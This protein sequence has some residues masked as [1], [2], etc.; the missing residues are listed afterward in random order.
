MTQQSNHRDEL[1]TI[2]GLLAHRAATLR[3]LPFI[4][5]GDVQWSYAQT[6]ANAETT[7]RS[8]MELGCER[9][10]RVAMMVENRPEFISAWFGTALAGGVHV[11]INLEYRGDILRHVLSDITA[12]ILICEDYLLSNV[13]AVMKE[14]QHGMRTIVVLGTA[15][16]AIAYTDVRIIA[17]SEFVEAGTAATP[18]EFRK[19]LPGDLGAILLTSGTTGVSKGVMV[20]DKHCIYHGREAAQAY[21]MTSAD[22]MYTC[23]PLFHGNAEW[24]TVLCALS[25][26]ASVA[27]SKRFSAS[28]FWE[29]VRKAGA[30]QIAFLGTM[31]HIL[32]GQPE[33]EADRSHRVRIGTSV[34]CPPDVMVAFERRFGFPLLETFGT[35]ETKRILSNLHYRRRIGSAGLPTP[36][37]TVEIHDAQ[38]WP[39]PI[40]TVG[41]L[42]YR[43]KEP[44]ILTLGYLNR[45]DATLESL[46]NGWWYTGDLAWQDSDGF[47]YFAGRKKD[48][49][50]RRGENVS[51]FEV[52]RALITHADVLLVAVVAAPSA[53]SEDEILAVV[54]RKN[55]SV[56]TEAEI[57][58]HA[59][60]RLPSFMV[61]R[62]I[63][64]VDE[65]PQTPTGKIAKE[66]LAKQVMQQ[67]VWDCEAAGISATK[68][69]QAAKLQC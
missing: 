66:G 2:Y 65:L 42:A 47:V 6:L 7:A 24:A 68:A 23:L 22:V 35:T 30:T 26:G 46:R 58:A 67:T 38:G 37:S 25:A 11:P 18:K 60:E 54:V 3:N 4:A 27:V 55:G 21:G 48:A 62:F 45:P 69:G 41:E 16:D 52:E 34:P 31:L 10:A 13:L 5:F 61:P 36:S 19:R 64:F 59:N 1:N 8:L 44:G 33:S 20:S 51:A 56:I 57:F 12:T 49:L 63:A 53:L 28:R 43:P 39:A 17:W 9:G 15:P 32:M 50:R 29:Q 40:G 14:S